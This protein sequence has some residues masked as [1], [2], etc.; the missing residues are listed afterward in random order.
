MSTLGPIRCVTI[1]APE[2]QRMIDVYHLY[3]GYELVDSGKLSAREAGLWGK[4]ELIGRRYALMLP[5]GEGQTYLR[6]IESK[7]AAS[8]TPFLHF[9]WNA[10]ELMV[11]N[12]DAAAARLADS[13]FKIVGPPANLSFSD[14][15]RA[16]Q[17]VGPSKEALYLTHFKERMAEFD[18]PEAKHFIDRTFIVIVG[19]TTVESINDFYTRHFSVAKAGVI[20]VVIG[21]LS[22]AHG[23]PRETLHPLAA[24]TL[25]GQ[26]F[27]E[28]DG[29][30]AG[31]VARP[32]EAGELPAG[33][34]MVS[35]GVE[36]LPTSI[37]TWLAPGDTLATP[38]YHGKR[39]A[40]CTGA[41]GEWIELIEQ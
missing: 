21:V 12:A 17:V 31:T 35:F 37:D 20:P 34:A 9:G 30:P 19:G 26:S 1:A 22:A 23:L 14:K 5:G 16:M 33:I 27:I 36:S 25:N 3:L 38:P 7:V 40:V 32:A 15:I 29:M 4:P 6:F 18:T 28:A 13:P 41:A 11:Q 24:L 8:Y 2:L 10:A 39:A